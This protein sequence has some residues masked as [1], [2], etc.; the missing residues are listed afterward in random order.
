MNRRNDKGGKSGILNTESRW[1]FG[2][3]K[4][5]LRLGVEPA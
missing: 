1:L 3:I 2:I 4:P 5:D